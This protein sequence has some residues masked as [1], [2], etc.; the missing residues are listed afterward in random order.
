[1]DPILGME[2]TG[3][4]IS[5]PAYDLVEVQSSKGLKHTAICYHDEFI[6][7]PALLAD[8]KEFGKFMESPGVTGLV[9]LADKDDKEGQYLYPTGTAWSVAEVIRAYADLGETCGLRAGLELAYV[10]SQ[11]LQEAE[12]KAAEFELYNHGSL[13][14]WSLMIKADGQVQ[15]IGYGF[16]QVEVLDFLEDETLMPKEDAFRYAPPERLADEGED[17]SSDLFSLSLVALELMTGRPVYDGLINDIR[18][19]ATRAEGAYRLYKWR[20]LLPE[21]VREALGR[22]LKYDPDARYNSATEFVYAVHDL[23]GTPDIEGRSLLEVMRR[24]KHGQ[25]SAPL[26][27]GRTA[28][29]TKDE[30]AR[31]AAELDDDEAEEH[32]L[33]PPKRPRPGADE[34]EEEEEEQPQKRW[35]KVERPGRRTRADR[36]RERPTR[37]GRERDKPR[38]SAGARSSG[39]ARSSA[40]SSTT[41]D[42]RERLRRGRSS[43]GVGRDSGSTVRDSGGTRSARDSRKEELRSSLEERLRDS[44]GSGKPERNEEPEEPVEAEE[45]PEESPEPEPEEQDMAGEEDKGASSAAALLAR[46]RSSAGKRPAK[47]PPPE[48]PDP[49]AS[50]GTVQREAPPPAPKPRPPVERASSGATRSARTSKRDHSNDQKVAFEILVEG[51]KPRRTKL[52][53]GDSLAETADRLAHALADLPLD[54]SGHL[55]GWYRIEQSGEWFAGHETVDALDPD[56]PVALAFVR[57]RILPMTFEVPGIDPPAR[58]QAPVGTAVPACSLVQCVE[59]ML[60]LAPGERDLY[61]E[62]EQLDPLQILE[63]FEPSAGQVVVVKS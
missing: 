28:A 14:P 62:G 7:H 2:Q 24:V 40:G 35:G 3:R 11:I 17:L 57:N 5:G 46:L 18:Q 26:V 6:E 45:T 25:Q 51:D 53:L 59:E 30:L 12:E 60:G 19:Q 31:L 43:G 23:L 27:G 16:P 44:L 38:R 48:E 42:L 37:V 63:D 56:K 10:A 36:K 33:P 4:R 55:R 22:A 8:L 49:T 50:G 41:E 15:I 21:Q 32:A 52:R 47:G 39:G 34:E 29:L 54:L 13:S 20:N 9:E 1:M 58:F 61:V